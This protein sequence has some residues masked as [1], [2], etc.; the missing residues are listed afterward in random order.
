MTDKIENLKKHIHEGDVDSVRESLLDIK[1]DIESGDVDLIEY[2]ATPANITALH[3]DLC[4]NLGTNRRLLQLRAR[5]SNG[6]HRSALFVQA[7]I[8]AVGY[9]S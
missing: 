7:M 9:L 4:D 1:Q 6:A 2:I 5:V 3:N 8:N